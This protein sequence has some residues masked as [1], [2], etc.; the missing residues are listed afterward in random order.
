MRFEIGK[1]DAYGTW[2]QTGSHM[3]LSTDL[4]SWHWRNPLNLLPLGILV[5]TA[6][7]LVLLVL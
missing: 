7:A 5:L 4:I 2:V 3:P 6:V 1:D